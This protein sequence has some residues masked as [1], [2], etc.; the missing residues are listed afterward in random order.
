[1]LF[2]NH[3]IPFP[4]QNHSYH[5]LAR[6]SRGSLCSM[7]CLLLLLP[8]NFSVCLSPMLLSFYLTLFSS[9]NNKGTVH[10]IFFVYSR[11]NTVPSLQLTVMLKML[12]ELSEFA[13]LVAE[14]LIEPEDFS[15]S[16]SRPISLQRNLII[17]MCKRAHLFSLMESSTYTLEKEQ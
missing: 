17:L 15:G 5:L 13:L 9:M 11:S 16:K 2:P 1:M 10:I 14:V 8:L 12:N 6:T 7:T 3:P 4:T